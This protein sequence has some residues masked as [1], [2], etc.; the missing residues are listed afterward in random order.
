[1]FTPTSS[2]FFHNNHFL[3]RVFTENILK[4]VNWIEIFISLS[5]KQKIFK[6]REKRENIYCLLKV[7]VN[8]RIQVATLSKFKR[9]YL[10]C[11]LQTIKSHTSS[12]FSQPCVVLIGISKGSEFWS[13][14]LNSGGIEDP[15]WVS[16]LV[17]RFNHPLKCVCVCVSSEVLSG[18]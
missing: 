16:S 6:Y 14:C 12:F 13:C 3:Q 9:Q 2:T 10:K 18:T 5:K 4:C 11:V 1:M 15:K 7:S 8:Q 17:G